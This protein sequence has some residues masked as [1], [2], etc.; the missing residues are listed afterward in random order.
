M[1]NKYFREKIL[2]LGSI[3]LIV[4]FCALEV[5]LPKRKKEPQ[6]REFEF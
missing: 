4:S 1:A 2:I 3:I 5:V 6:Q